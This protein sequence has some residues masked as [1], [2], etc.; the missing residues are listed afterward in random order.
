MS[1]GLAEYQ[2]LLEQVRRLH[3][4]ISTI[5]AEIATEAE[6]LRNLA[7]SAAAVGARRTLSFGPVIEAVRECRMAA[8]QPIAGLLEKLQE[9]ESTQ[10]CAAQCYEQ[11]TAEERV[12]QIPASVPAAKS[13]I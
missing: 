4:E 13:S 9:L 6:T 12:G 3:Q 10:A 8:L 11:L 2:T 1:N 5:A 7:E